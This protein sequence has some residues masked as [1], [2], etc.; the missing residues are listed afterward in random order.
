MGYFS[1]DSNN[2]SRDNRGGGRGFGGGRD[3]GGRDGR[4]SFRNDGPREMFK[5]TCSNCGKD[6]EVPFKPTSGKPVY[7]PDCFETIGGRSDRPDKS[8]RGDRLRP[9]FDRHQT[10]AP[11][12][13][14]SKQFEDLNRKLDKIIELLTPKSEAVVTTEPVIIEEKAVKAPKAKK[15]KDVIEK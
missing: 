7:C 9:S 12:I 11:R 6:C 5:T 4:P 10:P 1:R 2:R 13:D 3:R 15:A 8:D 14:N